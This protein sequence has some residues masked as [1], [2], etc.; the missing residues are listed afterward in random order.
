MQQNT[1]SFIRE[2]CGG[3]ACGMRHGPIIAR[4]PGPARTDVPVVMGRR[5]T[6]AQRDGDLRHVWEFGNHLR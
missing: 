2:R 1:S 6:L 4:G 3:M 5:K